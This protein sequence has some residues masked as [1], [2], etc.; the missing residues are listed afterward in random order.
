MGYESTA[1]RLLQA[2]YALVEFQP[3]YYFTTSGVGV[4]VLS[5]QDQEVCRF[6]GLIEPLFAV[7]LFFGGTRAGICCCDSLTSGLDAL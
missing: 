3:G 7:E 4:F 2:A 1:Q 6:S 5:G